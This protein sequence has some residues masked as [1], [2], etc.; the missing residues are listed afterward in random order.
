MV[1]HVLPINIF[2]EEECVYFS[3]E[4]QDR[5]WREGEADCEASGN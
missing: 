3:N 5:T 1:V 4:E 2:A